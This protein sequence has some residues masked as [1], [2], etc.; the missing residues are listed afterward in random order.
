M[1]ASRR[2]SEAWCHDCQ[3]DLIAGHDADGAAMRVRLEP[4]P[5]AA[6]YEAWALI[7]GWRTHWIAVAHLSR[8]IVPRDHWSIAA[9]SQ[10]VLYLDHRCGIPVPAAWQIAAA[11]ELAP[12]QPTPTPRRPPF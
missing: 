8:L 11:P 2:I 9:N 4:I 1:T 6:T 10:A 3:C 5:I 12:G 7:A